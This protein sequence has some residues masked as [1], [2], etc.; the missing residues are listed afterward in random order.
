[1]QIV[2]KEALVL[3]KERGIH[4]KYLTP[5]LL[6]RISYITKGKSLESSK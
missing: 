6:E 3:A 5:F 1:M 4:G 2:I